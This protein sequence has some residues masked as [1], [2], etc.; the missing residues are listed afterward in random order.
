M[1]SKVKSLFFRMYSWNHRKPPPEAVPTSSMLVVDPLLSTMQVFR[2]AEARGE[3]SHICI[4]T[5]YYH[6][7]KQHIICYKVLHSHPNM[8]NSWSS[9]RL[10]TFGY[11]RKCST[12]MTYVR[13]RTYVRMCM[14]QNECYH[15]Y[16]RTRKWCTLLSSYICVP[17]VWHCWPNL[18]Q[19]FSGT[20]ARLV[21]V[22]HRN[23]QMRLGR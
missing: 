1:S 4:H 5:S 2:L 3:K 17:A 14:E 10:C 6:L 7:N 9:D 19:P 12:T 22:S 18:A 20:D 13:V 16:V 11:S 21:S 23:S 15:R 8:T